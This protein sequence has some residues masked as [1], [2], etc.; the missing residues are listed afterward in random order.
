M[1]D[2]N[3]NININYNIRTTGTQ[4][5]EAQ[6]N[7]AQKAT[8]KLNKST[9]DY[10]KEAKTA[11]S[12]STRG[13]QSVEQSA[14]KAAQGINT[15]VTAV[16]LFVAS[17]IVREVAQL[18]IEMSR[19]AGNTEGV[20]RA[21]RRA[22]PNAE[23]LLDN[24]R[25]AT[26]GTVTDFNL[27]TRTLQ[28]Q[29]L[30]V[31]VNELAVLLEFAAVRAQQTGQSVD[32]LVDSI[33]TGIG[34]KSLLILD[35]L[36]LSAVRL[37]EQFN[38]ASLEAQSV[39]DVT[40]GVANIAREELEKMGG[41]VETA[42]TKVDQLAVSWERAREEASKFFSDGQIVE[43]FKDYTE[44][45]GD[46]IE[47][48]R[49]GITVEE[50][51]Q[52]K[53]IQR[54]ALFTSQLFLQRN[55][56]GE[57]QKDSAFLQKTIQNLTTELGVRGRSLETQRKRVENL[58]EELRLGQISVRDY[59]EQIR[60][61]E[62][63]VEISEE[64]IKIRQEW[65]KIFMAQLAALDQSNKGAIPEQIGIIERL[66]EQIKSLNEQIR[67]A[68]TFEL[69]KKLS[70]ELD[71]A[72]RT[73]D[74]FKAS[75]ST[76]PPTVDLL[77]STIDPTKE[78][79]GLF[80]QGTDA[81]GEM[82]EKVNE[83]ISALQKVSS[84]Q[85]VPLDFAD[86]LSEEIKNAKEVLVD[87]GFDIISSQIID[88]AQA[89]VEGLRVQ[90]DE[91]RAFYDE[92]QILAGDNKRAQDQLRIEEKRA[93]RDAQIEIARRQ[94]EANRYSIIVDTA[95]GIIKAFATLPTPAA[96]VQSAIIA[97]L[98]ASQ[99]AVVNRTPIPR[100]AKGKIGIDGPGTGTSDSIH[101]MLSKGESVINADATKRSFGLLKAI[102]AKKIDDRIINELRLTNNGVTHVPFDDSR[103]VEAINRKKDVDFER[104]GSTL[105]KYETIRNGYRRKVRSKIM[106]K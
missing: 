102:N 22:F 50:L 78:V 61:R 87:T 34:R 48:Q 89:N 16:K 40:R 28:A 94:K 63:V 85:T 2:R 58:R 72:Q 90:L 45:L 29:N 73:L 51:F 12:E 27:M 23:V 32:Y 9:K 37:K 38:G 55:L 13:F 24:L 64:E 70:H 52:E 96:I 41:Y 11:T 49:R 66:E 74:S 79:V 97:A 83:L 15:V 77:E 67:K 33:V 43:F 91:L 39:A 103:M 68:P 84:T 101:A 62:R 92:Q 19:L 106:R 25:K 54:E 18:S 6:V 95:A 5:V 31:S 81:A 35:N 75:I 98:G 8:E 20:E 60:I 82:T 99:L 10:G 3:A 56:T 7:K 1:A 104:I 17:Q 76:A 26:R 21:F 71:I 69:A 44:S 30:G 86:L 105:Y 88:V 57:Q 42:A 14:N 4:S 47:A 65:L 53:L 100:F 46:L 80:E 59:G 36:G 93:T